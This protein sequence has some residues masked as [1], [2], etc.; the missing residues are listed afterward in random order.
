[1]DRIFNFNKVTYDFQYSITNFDKITTTDYI[2]S[3]DNTVLNLYR[4]ALNKGI[5][6]FGLAISGI[7]SELIASSINRF[8]LPVEY[9]FL[10]IKGI[11]DHQ[12][13]LAKIVAKKYNTKLNIIERTIDQVLNVDSIEIFKI[14]PVAFPG[15]NI[16]PVITKFI[17]K[18]FFIIIGEGDLEKTGVIKYLSIYNN[19]VKKYN[20]DLFYIPMHL[21][22]IIYKSCLDYYGKVGECNFY[23]YDFNTWYHILRDA[24]L[25]TNGKFFYDPKSKLIWNMCKNNFIYQE[26]TDT[27]EYGKNF[28]VVSKILHDLPK[29]AKIGWHRYIGDVVTV[30]KDLVF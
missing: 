17:P 7:D 25:R 3:I 13:P 28:S 22:E 20:S 30:P 27:F 12:L 11:N 15:Y 10:H 8:K 19:K 21:S 1:M 5:D 23:S 24:N 16:N 14:C 2:E 29:T 6:K 4:Q 9:F 26:K 18:D